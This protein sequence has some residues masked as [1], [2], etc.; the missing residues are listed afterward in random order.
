MISF[1]AEKLK[2]QMWQEHRKNA[3]S[4]PAPNTQLPCQNF[5]PA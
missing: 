5:Y 1:A 2:Q 3:L 4:S